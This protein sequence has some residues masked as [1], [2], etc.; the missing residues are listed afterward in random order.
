MNKISTPG[1]PRVLYRL[2]LTM[3]LV[4]ICQGVTYGVSDRQK[5]KE[6]PDIGRVQILP[7][8]QSNIAKAAAYDNG[9]A[10]VFP[11][12]QLD[13]DSYTNYQGSY[14]GDYAWY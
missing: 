8:A 2:I 12:N 4:G 5:E 6:H 7:S 14:L 11:C 13:T 10:I 3:L 9:I 1:F